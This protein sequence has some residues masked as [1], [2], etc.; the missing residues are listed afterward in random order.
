MFCSVFLSSQ[1]PAI[2]TPAAFSFLSFSFSIQAQGQA[3]E[4]QAGQRVAWDFKCNR[5]RAF[6]YMSAL[7]SLFEWICK[8]YN[9]MAECSDK[10]ER[11][12]YQNILVHEKRIIKCFDLLLWFMVEAAREILSFPS[13]WNFHFLSSLGNI[14]PFSGCWVDQSSIP[15]TVQPCVRFWDEHT[16]IRAQIRTPVVLSQTQPWLY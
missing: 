6:M 11:K 1:V 8:Q 13:E 9:I 14:S 10:T 2:L 3:A 12:P 15:G 5:S 7:E 4:P 16:L